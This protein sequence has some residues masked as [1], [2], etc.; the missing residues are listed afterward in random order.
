MKC[1]FM[2]KDIKA[3]SMSNEGKTLEWHNI[4]EQNLIPVKV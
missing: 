1:I 3:K 4:I 2:V